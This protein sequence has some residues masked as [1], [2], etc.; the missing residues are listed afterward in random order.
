MNVY[1]YQAALYCEDCGWAIRERSTATCYVA[2]EVTANLRELRQIVITPDTDETEYDSD[3]YPKGPYP[4]GGGE[5]D[6]PQHCDACRVFLRNPLT[7]YGYKYV[8]DALHDLSLREMSTVER[9]WAGYY[10]FAD[11]YDGH[12][13]EPRASV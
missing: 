10:G 5:A 1:I 8:Q 13:V 11:S 2:V 7:T 3:D 6:S 12:G 4:D 9:E